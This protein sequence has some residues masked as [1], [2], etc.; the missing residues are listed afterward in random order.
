METENSV[1]KL[2][3]NTPG[4]FFAIFGAV[5]WQAIIIPQLLRN[6]QRMSAYALAGSIAIIV[7]GGTII[8]MIKKSISIFKAVNVLLNLIFVCYLG[9]AAA[10]Y[11]D[12]SYYL[13]NM[14]KATVWVIPAVPLIIQAGLV[15]YRTHLKSNQ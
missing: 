7:I 10:F 4:W 11:F 2:K 9:T 3:W 1:T 8:F 5:I 14:S 6:D 15:A 12:N 13:L